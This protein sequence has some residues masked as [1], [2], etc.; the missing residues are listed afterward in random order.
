MDPKLDDMMI[1]TMI[2]ELGMSQNEPVGVGEQRG[3]Q[4]FRH[5]VG[6]ANIGSSSSFTVNVA[7]C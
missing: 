3:P 2:L 7:E 4:L 6:P 5:L 1:Q